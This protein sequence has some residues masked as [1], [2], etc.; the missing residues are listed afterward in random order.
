MLIFYY[1]LLF[2]YPV[3]ILNI[4]NALVTTI[5]PALRT[6]TNV[7]QYLGLSF[8]N[9]SIHQRNDSFYCGATALVDQGLLIVEDS[10]SHSDT[11]H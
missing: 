10:W 2:F 4:Y 11:P 8:Q 3:F 6:P 1:I 7:L 5:T 9:T